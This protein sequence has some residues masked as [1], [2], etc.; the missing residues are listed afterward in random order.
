MSVRTPNSGFSL[1]ELMAALVIVGVLATLAVPAFT[2]YIYKS[3]V[4]EATTFLGQI[5]QRQEAYRYEFGQ[6]AAVNGTTW[7]TYN[8]TT[9]P[10]AD[11]VVWESTTAWDQLGANPDGLI[12]FQ[13]A[14]IAGAPGVAAPAATNLDISDFWFAAQAKADLD[15][16]GTTFFMEIY[17]QSTH[18]YNSQTEKAGWE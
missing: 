17:S 3:R 15:A 13:Y 5:K 6:Y 10:G 12:R 14:T 7:G 9:V 16:D 1:I 18:I 4:T 8:P 11:P 2:S